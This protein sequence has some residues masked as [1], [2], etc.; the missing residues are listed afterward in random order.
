MV[1]WYPEWL[2]SEW[3]IGNSNISSSLFLTGSVWVPLYQ[4]SAQDWKK[5]GNIRHRT[6]KRLSHE[7]W[8]MMV[9]EKIL[10]KHALT[11]S[12]HLCS[13][14]TTEFLHQCSLLC[15]FALCVRNW[16][17]VSWTKLVEQSKLCLDESQ[18]L[19]RWQNSCSLLWNLFVC[20]HGNNCSW[21]EELVVVLCGHRGN[22]MP[23]LFIPT[24]NSLPHLSKRDPKQKH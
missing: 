4:A 6:K 2:R 9:D 5:N 10:R 15:R 21:V 16:S 22:R 1:Q 3:H 17:V 11:L 23:A 13:Q 8:P 12:S 7:R 24:K 19:P 20:F 14:N 18:L